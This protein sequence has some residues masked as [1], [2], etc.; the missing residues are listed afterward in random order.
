MLCKESEDFTKNGFLMDDFIRLVNNYS[1]F[2]LCYDL[3]DGQSSKWFDVISRNR[4]AYCK[5]QKFTVF[6]I[7]SVIR[8][9]VKIRKVSF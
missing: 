6:L 1:Q 8:L 5:K 4:M 3:L 7:A 9:V 2:E